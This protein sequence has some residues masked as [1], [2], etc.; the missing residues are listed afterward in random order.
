MSCSE[1]SSS[2]SE[3]SSACYAAAC[4]VPHLV[5]GPIDRA[6]QE[7]KVLACRDLRLLDEVV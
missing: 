3:L 1:G 5:R 4:E 2:T 6:E 7:Q